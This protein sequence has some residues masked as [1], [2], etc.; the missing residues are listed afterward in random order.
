MLDRLALWRVLGVVIKSGETGTSDH[1]P[2]RE[3]QIS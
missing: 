1:E 2:N 3:Q